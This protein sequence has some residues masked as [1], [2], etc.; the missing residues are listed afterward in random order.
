VSS[1]P[2]HGQERRRGPANGGAMFDAAIFTFLVA[3][4]ATPVSW[5][6]LNRFG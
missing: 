5:W 2:P 3:A 1:P 6:G 4:V